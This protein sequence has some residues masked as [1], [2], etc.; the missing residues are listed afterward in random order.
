MGTQ[1][2]ELGA[3]S[4]VCPP[5]EGLTLGRDPPRAEGSRSPARILPLPAATEGSALTHRG[6]FFPHPRVWGLSRPPL[7][8]RA[9]LRAV[10][11]QAQLRWEGEQSDGR[12]LHQA[13]D[14][15]PHVTGS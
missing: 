10:R 6:V 11:G 5:G 15:E 12:P 8:D 4:S 1:P 9:L 2:G 13:G 14:N 7:T 3:R